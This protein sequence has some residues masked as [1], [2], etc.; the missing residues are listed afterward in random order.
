[1]IWHSEEAGTEIRKKDVGTVEKG[2]NLQR[3]IKM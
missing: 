3:D 2:S 1:M